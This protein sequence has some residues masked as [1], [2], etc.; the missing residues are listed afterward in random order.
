[1]T[2]YSDDDIFGIASDE[3]RVLVTP[4]GAEMTSIRTGDKE[5]LWQGDPTWWSFRAPLLFPVI[6]TSP[7]GEVAVDGWPYPMLPHGFARHSVFTPVHHDTNCLRL[8]LR[9]SPE[10]RRSFPFTFCL[11]VEY[12]VDEARL[13]VTA[14]IRNEDTRPMPFQF[15]FH[16]AF[17]LPLAGGKSTEHTLILDQEAEPE[18]RRPSA[19]GLMLPQRRPSP[20]HMGRLTLAPDLFA[21]GAMVFD[22]G[23]CG[24][25]EISSGSGPRVTMTARNLPVL[26]LWQKQDAPFLCLEPWTGLPPDVGGDP[27]LSQRP[28]I[29]ILEAGKQDEVKMLLEFSI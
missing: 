11:T 2:T 20:F 13:E 21:N 17:A 1:M 27:E 7:D 16:P 19:N 29:R 12:R 9:D 4:R 24:A 14:T 25:L 23:I 15:G 26:A 6:G 18:M 22:D 5:W 8:E 10:T 3:L 28:A